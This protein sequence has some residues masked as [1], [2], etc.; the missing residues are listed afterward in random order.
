MSPHHCSLFSSSPGRRG[1]LRGRGGLI[2]RTPLE[3]RQGGCASLDAPPE[4]LVPARLSNYGSARAYDRGIWP[5]GG[6]K[7]AAS[8]VGTHE[9]TALSQAVWLRDVVVGVAGLEPATSWSQTKRAT[10][11]A[12]PRADWEDAVDTADSSWHGR[13]GGSSRCTRSKSSELRFG[14]GGAGGEASCLS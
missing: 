3:P 6:P 2:K 1:A 12:T 10:D 11:C 14:H 4:R 5:R 13:V 8:P 7:A 9:K